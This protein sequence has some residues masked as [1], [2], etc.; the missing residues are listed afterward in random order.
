V[1]RVLVT[2]AS[3]FLGAH[4]LA[5]L[6]A[7]GWSDVHAVSRS[8][9]CARGVTWHACDLFDAGALASLV[10]SLRP[11]HTLHLAWTATP[12]KY[13]TS[14]DNELWAAASMRLLEELARAGARRLVCAGSCAEYS[15]KYGLCSEKTTPLAPNSPY[16]KSK[17]A[18]QMLLSS[19]GSSLGVSTAWGRVFFPYGPYEHRDRLTSYV[20]RSLLAGERALCTTGDHRRDFLYA[21]DVADAFVTLLESDLDGPINIGSGEAIAVKTVVAAIGKCIGRPELIQLGA[22]PLLADEPDLLV[23]DVQRLRDQLGWSPHTT[24]AQGI[25]E[26]V[27]FW[28]RH[29]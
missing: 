16:G 23:A 1:R 13:W 4:C 10:Q 28:K 12:G 18:L 5:A 22:R 8:A 21:G 14:P 26:S 3:G 15:W 29:G 20:I 7:R 9:G 24:L 17:H 19:T 6:A 25:N 2:G 27:E 11:S